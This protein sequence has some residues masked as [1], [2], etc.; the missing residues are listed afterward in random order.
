MRDTTIEVVH[1]I[2]DN[3]V[4]LHPKDGK[5]VLQVFVTNVFDAKVVHAQVEPCDNN[6]SKNY[7]V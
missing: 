2:F 1:P 4:R 6:N 5:K 7:T 3:V